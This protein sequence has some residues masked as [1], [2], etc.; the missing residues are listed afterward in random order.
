MSIL[1]QSLWVMEPV[2]SSLAATSSDHTEQ[3]KPALSCFQIAHQ[4][5]SHSGSLATVWQR[6]SRKDK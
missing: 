5:P 3:K 2:T 6:D 1:W 4:V